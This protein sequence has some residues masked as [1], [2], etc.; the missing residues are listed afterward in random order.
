MTDEDMSQID[1][2][3][4]QYEDDDGASQF[5]VDQTPVSNSNPPANAATNRY[6]DL[7]K[8]CSSLGA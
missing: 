5:E 8:F 7:A 6:G 2:E 4:S 3:E 1:D